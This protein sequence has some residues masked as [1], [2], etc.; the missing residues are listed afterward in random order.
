MAPTIANGVYFIRN[1]AAPNNVLRIDPLKR[2]ISGTVDISA[3][4]SQLFK[5]EF[6]TDT[7]IYLLTNPST[8][9]A[10]EVA[11]GNSASGTPVVL[12]SPSGGTSQSWDIQPVIG[13]RFA[14]PGCHC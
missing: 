4:D 13:Q 2:V 11:G 9:F 5:V 12:S 1:T 14:A 6:Q 7:N 8:G 10:L 3:L